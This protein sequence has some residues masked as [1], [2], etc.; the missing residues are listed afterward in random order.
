MNKTFYSLGLMSGTSGDGVD[1][2]IISSDGHDEYEEIKNEYFRYDDRIYENI[3][4][5][6][7]KISKFKDL[8][9]HVNEIRDLEKEIS[10][11][12]A[13]IA[14]KMQGLIDR[15]VDLIGFHGQTIYH[16]SL[17]KISKQI[18]NGNL[19]SQLTKKT[20]VYNF[21][22]NDIKNGGEGAPLAPAFHRLIVKKKKNRFTRLYTKYRRNSECDSDRRI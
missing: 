22:Q 13:E 8:N 1:A 12:H 19:L 14:T 4:I 20:V 18:G 10:L 15:K 5:L 11:F 21:R 3:H 17:E 16:N 7:G 9:N 2:S 6:K